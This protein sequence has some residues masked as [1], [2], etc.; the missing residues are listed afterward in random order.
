VEKYR[1][2][3]KKIFCPR[4][5]SKKNHGK[6]YQKPIKSTFHNPPLCVKFFL[7]ILKTASVKT[8]ENSVEIVEKY[9]ENLRFS[10]PVE[11]LYSEKYFI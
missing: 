8:V 10:Q 6:L 4:L 9:E 5:P 3:C 1:T 2:N 7:H 11:K